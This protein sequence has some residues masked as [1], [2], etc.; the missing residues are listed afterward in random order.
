[1]MCIHVENAASDVVYELVAE[2]QEE[3]EAPEPQGTLEEQQ[4]P[5]QDPE[6]QITEQQEGKLRSMPLFQLMSLM[7]I[8]ILCIYVS[9]S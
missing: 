8:Y 3:Q 2:P 4:D 6:E 7:F 1:H 9:R 5:A